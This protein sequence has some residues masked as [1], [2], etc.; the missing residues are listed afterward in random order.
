MIVDLQRGRERTGGVAFEDVDHGVLGV[1]AV[2]V[3]A[4]ERRGRAQV[5]G[6]A[7]TEPAHP[8]GAPQ[9]GDA[10]PNGLSLVMGDF[11]SFGASL[12]VMTPEG[13]FGDPTGAVSFLASV[14]ERTSYGYLS[15]EGPLQI[16]IVDAS[17]TVTFLKTAQLKPGDVPSVT[18]YLVVGSGDAASVM[19]PMYE[20]AQRPTTRLQGIV[21]DEGGMPIA[22]ARVSL[23]PAPYGP[24]QHLIT[25]AT[26][27]GEGH[28]RIE[29]PAGDYVALASAVGRTVATRCGQM[30]SA[31]ISASTMMV[32]TGNTSARPMTRADYAVT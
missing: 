12:S 7:P 24:T 10:D 23:L 29:V 5:L 4:G 1:A 26:C 9:P 19:G 14:G 17:G 28:Y 11:L 20:L 16:P 15:M 3:P 22:N 27:D 18:R 6:S 2:L 21:R 13:G 30:F 8:A 32:R 31:G 25:Q